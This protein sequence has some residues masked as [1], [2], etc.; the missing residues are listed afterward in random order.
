MHVC[1]CLFQGPADLYELNDQLQQSGFELNCQGGVMKVSPLRA[2]QKHRRP[3][4][5]NNCWCL[6]SNYD[7]ACQIKYLCIV[8]YVVSIYITYIPI[9]SCTLPIYIYLGTFWN[10]GRG[11]LQ[12]TRGLIFGALGACTRHMIKICIPWDQANWETDGVW[13]TGSRS[14]HVVGQLGVYVAHQ[15]LLAADQVPSHYFI[16][17]LS[18]LFSLIEVAML[19]VEHIDWAHTAG[20]N[21]TIFFVSLDRRKW[22]AVDRLQLLCPPTVCVQGLTGM[23]LAAQCVIWTCGQTGYS[24][25]HDDMHHNFLSVLLWLPCRSAQMVFCAKAPHWQIAGATLLLAVKLCRC[26]PLTLSLL[27]DW[28]CL[29]SSIC[30]WAA[31]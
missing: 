19:V 3:M 8:V 31:P 29:S 23:L 18:C 21:S 27:R 13:D 7:F 5:G 28:F 25:M 22:Q 1:K 4:L 2:C 14:E 12:G 10:L 20:I 9:Y 16:E 24:A 26:L 11:K 17:H 6:Y 15:S 30:G